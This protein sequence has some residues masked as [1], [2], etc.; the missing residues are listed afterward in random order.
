MGI[1]VSSS[2]PASYPSLEN[3]MNLA[4]SIV[5]DTT[6][7]VTN[8]PGEGNILT[9]N[10]T[11][12]P[13]AQ[14]FLNSAIREVYREL[15]N[16]GDPELIVDNW[17]VKGLTP[18]NG[19]GGLAGPDPAVQVQL[20]TQGYF[21]GTNINPIVLLPQNMMY[22]LRLWER[23]NG[24]N[25]PFQDMHQPEFGLPSRNQTTCLIEWEWR[26]NMLCFVGATETRDV[27]MRF[28][29]ALPQF[30]GTTIN[31][32]ITYVPIQDSID[33][34]AYKLAFKYEAM[35]GSPQL[36]QTQ[37]D[38]VEQMRQLKSAIT[39]RMQTIEFYRQPFGSQDDGEFSNSNF[40]Q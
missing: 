14:Q 31:Y 37:K 2:I 8:T 18:V 11:I 25:N 4:R 33:A 17:I 12:A 9:D 29:Q 23:Q 36:A 21:D 24:T 7:G 30:F 10:P 15:A 3:I 22:P 40:G 20:T 38:S 34:I 28:I 19:A 1:V 26:E 13:F 39:R 35:L 16:I 5:N 32:A 6:A 27:R